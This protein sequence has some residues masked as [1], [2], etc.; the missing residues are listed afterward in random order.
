[1]PHRRAA[2]AVNR[3]LSE[4][5]KLAVL[6]AWMM[7]I[8]LLG[9]FA[10]LGWFAATKASH[11]E[12][13]RTASRVNAAVIAREAQSSANAKALSCATQNLQNYRIRSFIAAVSPR[14]LPLA[15][16]GFPTFDCVQWVKDP[17]HPKLA[18]DQGKAPLVT[19]AGL[20]VVPRVK[21]PPPAAVAG[22]PGSQG[23][24]GATGPA[25]VTGPR[26]PRG[27]AGPRGAPGPRGPVGP[28]GATG[29]IGSQGPKGDTGATGDQGPK[30]ER[31]E[32]GPAGP[33]GPAGPPGTPADAAAIAALQ[34]A[35]ARLDATIANLSSRLS[36]VEARVA[37]LPPFGG[38]GP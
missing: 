20:P 37:L 28:Q 15:T 27:P 31:G 1:M 17:L 38:P 16:R 34:A 36:A 2:R 22:S 23:P 19:G 8:S 9:I 13:A 24:P 18:K 29:F 3:L 4:Q 7:A 30:G 6:R 21:A 35:I 11:D 26:G 10:L 12:V 33:A 14:N 32:P 25:G 5:P